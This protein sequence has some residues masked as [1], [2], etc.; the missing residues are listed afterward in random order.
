MLEGSTTSSTQSNPGAS[1]P[2]TCT[3]PGAATSGVA[4][5]SFTVAVT[6]GRA[7]RHHGHGSHHGAGGTPPT[8]TSVDVQFDGTTVFVDPGNPSATIQNIAHGDR[9]ILVWSAPP[10][11]ARDDVPPASKV[12]DLGPR[13]P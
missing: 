5:S 9:L 10:G 7:P 4:G 1:A 8:T 13:T 11:S 6:T 3:V 12:V 2:V